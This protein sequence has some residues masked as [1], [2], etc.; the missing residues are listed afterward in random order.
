MNV[1][2]CTKE[3]RVVAVVRNFNLKNSQK[4]YECCLVALLIVR[5]QRLSGI[6]VLKYQ[7][8]NQCLKR[9]KSRGLYLSLTLLLSLSL[10]QYIKM[11]KKTCNKEF[12]KTL[13]V[14]CGCEKLQP[15]KTYSSNKI[16]FF[17][18]TIFVFKSSII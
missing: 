9:H 15:Q 6:Q 11:P 16:I 18:A 14:V 7:N 1:K 5:S 13:R 10:Y 4:K 3:G 2:T 8:C 17:L 12:L